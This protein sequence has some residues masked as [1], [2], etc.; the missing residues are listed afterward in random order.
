MKNFLLLFALVL[1]VTCPMETLA[2]SKRPTTMKELLK[3]TKGGKAVFSMCIAGANDGKTSL[4]RMCWKNGKEGGKIALNPHTTIYFKNGTGSARGGQY[5][6]TWKDRGGYVVSQF[7][8][9]TIKGK[10][11]KGFYM[12]FEAD[13]GGSAANPNALNP[14]EIYRLIK[15]FK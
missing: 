6:F 13:G 11:V 7:K 1:L 8:D 2:K 10:L 5:T 14:P 9:F 4:E 15:R 3:Y 12:T